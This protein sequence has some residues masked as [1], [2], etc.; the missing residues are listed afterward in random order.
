MLTFP[1]IDPIIFSIGPLKVRWYGLMYLLGFTATYFLVLHQLR[2]F[3]WEEL[4]ERF[5]SLNLYLIVG[6]ILGGRLG[7]VL[8]YQPLYYLRHPLEILATWEGGM[9]FHGGCIGV[10]AAGILFCRSHRLDFWKAADLYVVTAPIGLGLGRIGNFINGELFGRVTDVPWGMVFPH[11][12]PLP[13][14]PSQLY[15][16]FLEGVVLFV[17]LWSMRTKPWQR[18]SSRAWPAGSLLALFLV[19][20]GTVRFTI[21]FFREPD[22]QLGTLALFFTMGQV[23]STAMIAAGILLWFWRSRNSRSLQKG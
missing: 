5:D 9:S 22:P 13:R 14:H 4:R 18:P 2:S 10:I 3:R 20:Y 16:A 21:E 23:L 12:G 17:L 6:V 7:Y 8:F 15:E 1:R 19:A 11:G